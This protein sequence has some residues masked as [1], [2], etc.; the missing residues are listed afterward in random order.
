[1]RRWSSENVRP[2]NMMSLDF[3]KQGGRTESRSLPHDTVRSATRQKEAREELDNVGVGLAVVEQIMKVSWTQ[4]L[5]SQCLIMSMTFNIAQKSNAATIVVVYAE[6]HVLDSAGH[7][8]EP[9]PLQR[10]P[11]TLMDANARI[12]VRS[13][14]EG[15][16]I[17]LRMAR[18]L[19]PMTKT[20]FL[21]HSF[22]ASYGDTLALRVERVFNPL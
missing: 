5:I 18:I 16:K 12:W 13:G 8:Y 7:Q 14:E 20:K 10:E 1:M 9:N 15:Y 6:K 4:A 17:V 3:K 11:L 2:W 19:E 21:C 22:L